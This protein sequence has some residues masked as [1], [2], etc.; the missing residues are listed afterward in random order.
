VIGRIV[1]KVPD[2]LACARLLEPIQRVGLAVEVGG[3]GTAKGKLSLDLGPAAAQVASATMPIP[4]GFAKASTGAPVTAQWN[5]DVVALRA[6]AQP[7]LTT[8][9]DRDVRNGLD[10]LDRFGIRA[11]RAFVQRLDLDDKSGAG[12]VSLDLVHKRYLASLLDQVPMRD[13]LERN[14]K[15]GPLAGHT[16]AIPFM[17]SFDYVLNDKLAYAAMGDGLLAST[18][19]AGK[20]TPGPIAAIDLFPPAMPVATWKDLAEL[21]DVPESFV[22]R[23]LRWREAHVSLA[24]E[25]S[26]LVLAA[27]G[28][29]R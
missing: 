17:F 6:W 22:D 13:T 11:A 4:E 23:L 9:A 3:G 28:T 14:K 10:A 19:G 26:S 12:V 7:C 24:I 21:A 27:S 8:V 29:R 15:F 16:I 5:L 20:A 25:G 2:A 1:A 18:V